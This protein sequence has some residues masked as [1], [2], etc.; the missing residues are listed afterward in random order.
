MRTV[1]GDNRRTANAIGAT[2]GISAKAVLLP[3]W[4]LAEIALLKR[5][6]PGAMVGDG[7]DDAPALVAAS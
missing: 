5:G 4:K 1:T 6:E 2:I 3:D 7:I